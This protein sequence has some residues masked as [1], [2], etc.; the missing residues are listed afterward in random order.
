[1]ILVY[2]RSGT[3]PQRARAWLFPPED[4]DQPEHAFARLQGYS[5]AA[6]F[7]IVKG[8]RTTPIRKN[9]RCIHH[10]SETRNGCKPSAHVER[11]PNDSKST[12]KR[13]FTSEYADNCAW[14]WYCVPHVVL[15][16]EDNEDRRW[17][18]R[19][20]KTSTCSRSHRM[21]RNNNAL[22][23]PINKKARPGTETAKEQGMAMRNVRCINKL[24][25]C[26]GASISSLIEKL[27]IIW[28]DL[29]L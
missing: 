10:G 16:E 2:R 1:M 24:K 19:R 3:E 18:W 6:E 21:S 11:D 15:D 22:Q 8:Q 23:Y 9:Y 7:C 5:L 14:R 28:Q 27:T 17:I 13:E 29:G 12:R 4:G 25:K 20:D 26:Y